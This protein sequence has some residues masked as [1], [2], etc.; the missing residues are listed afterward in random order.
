MID[1]HAHILPGVDDGAPD[2]ETALEMAA[3]AADS[4]V[5][6]L[7]ATPHCNIPGMYRNYYDEN[8]VKHFLRFQQEVKK[9]EIPL[10]V[11]AGMEI[12]AT[13]ELP[14]L[15]RKNKVLGLNG[16]NY[17][18]MEFDFDEDPFFCHSILKKC[19]E[20]GYLPIIA[21]PERYYFVQRHPEI[22]FEWYE[23]GYFLQV[24]KGSIQG[25]FG[26]TAS[27]VARFLLENRAVCCVA[28][29]AHSSWSRTTHMRE[30]QEYLQEIYGVDYAEKL[31]LENPL[32]ILKG[33]IL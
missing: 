10:Q 14:A 21:H 11:F 25:R 15:L 18:L 27:G 20:N 4:G 33:L 32:K 19:K 7:V 26:R 28:S 1:I 12:Y 16:T 5:K 29:D 8:L 24:N 22:A 17:L 30:I 6:Y 31:L 23:D 13:K 9:A 2:M 3:M